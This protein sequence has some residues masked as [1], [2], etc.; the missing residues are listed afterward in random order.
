MNIEPDLKSIPFQEL[1]KDDPQS[2]NP[3]NSITELCQINS[4]FNL[5]NNASFRLLL[6]SLD[7]KIWTNKNDP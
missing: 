3:S 1:Q 4:F 2:R 6:A 5:E 7:F